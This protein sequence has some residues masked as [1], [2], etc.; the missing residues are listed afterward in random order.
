[1]WNMQA[2]EDALVGSKDAASG[3]SSSE[4]DDEIGVSPHRVNDVDNEERE[5]N[6]T[7]ESNV[8]T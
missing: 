6:D 4:E 2:T 3:S 8:F 1:M 7:L 5:T